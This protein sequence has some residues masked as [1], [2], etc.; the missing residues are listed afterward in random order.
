[1]ITIQK[2][3][4][5]KMTRQDQIGPNCWINLTRP[6]EEELNRV[7]SALNIE[8]DFLRAALDEEETSHVDTEEGQTL[9]IIDIPV[10][11][12]ENNLIYTTLPMG[13]IV[14]EQNII[15]GSVSRRRR[16]CQ[17]LSRGR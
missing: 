5:G 13:I 12:R 3:V 15:N 1:M 7:V 11:E 2:T 6:T 4:N 10:E 9:I 16:Y 14:T 8:P 17:I